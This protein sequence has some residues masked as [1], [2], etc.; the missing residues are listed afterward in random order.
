MQTVPIELFDL[1]ISH[2]KQAVLSELT[3]V[4][5]NGHAP[6]KRARTPATADATTV[7]AFLRK[8]PGSSSGDV[9]TGI[10][11]DPKAAL[12]ELRASKRV[13]MTGNKRGARY[14]VR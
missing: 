14:S 7:L 13:R 9:A 11:G 8:H 10:G 3:A 2:V 12:L 5:G 1:I 6:T 4:L